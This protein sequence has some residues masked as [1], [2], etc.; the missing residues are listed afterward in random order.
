MSDQKSFRDT[1]INQL[2]AAR[3]KPKD[4]ERLMASIAMAVSDTDLQQVESALQE[5]IAAR[6]PRATDIFGK[7]NDYLGIIRLSGKAAYLIKN[8]AEWGPNTLVEVWDNATDAKEYLLRKGLE[9]VEKGQDDSGKTI[10]LDHFKAWRGT[11]TADE[12]AGVIYQPDGPSR[13]QERFNLWNGWGIAPLPGDKHHRFLDLLREG[14]CAGNTAYYEYVLN[15]LAHLLQKPVERPKTA[16]AIVSGQGAGKGT[17]I[18]VLTAMIGEKNCSGDISNKDLGGNFNSKI[19]NRLLINLNEATFS[20][21]H[22]QVEFM[23][24]LITDPTFRVE[25]KGLEAFDAPNFSRLI[26]TTN[27]ANWGRLAIDDRRYLILEPKAGYPED[28]EFF[29]ALRREMF[30]EGGVAH[31]AHFLRQ[32]NIADWDPA[33][34]P[35]RTTGMDT[36]EDSMKSRSDLFF[37][38]ELAGFGQ[39][40][41]MAYNG[42]APAFCCGDKPTFSA[43]FQAYETYCCRH[44]RMEPVAKNKFST[45][46]HRLGCRTVKRNNVTLITLPE[47]GELRKAIE[48]EIK[49]FQIPWAERF[50]EAM[51]E[52]VEEVGIPHCAI[53]RGIK[54]RKGVE[55]TH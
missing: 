11:P 38:Y 26:V 54:L 40:D 41:G 2:T 7:I 15:W 19:A 28:R 8:R 30:D 31:L 23:K 44:R 46:A 13:Y 20:G 45:F 53:A 25:Y 9:V 37:F 35:A 43:F 33:V 39:I 42:E 12:Y 50:P 4:R 36:L 3:L 48:A 16:I 14:F 1:L 5:L 34:L 51:D 47:K 32:R 17:L 55:L 6:K 52:D 10:T 22:E 21:N 18:E 24:K 49:G 29:T 27:N